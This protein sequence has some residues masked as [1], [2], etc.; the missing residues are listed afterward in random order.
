MQ[1]IRDNTSVDPC[2]DLPNELMWPYLMVPTYLME[3]LWIFSPYLGWLKDGTFGSCLS[4]FAS[5]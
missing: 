3:L 5:F 2:T 1:E 4:Y